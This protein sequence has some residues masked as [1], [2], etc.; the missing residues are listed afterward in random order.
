MPSMSYGGLDVQPS[1]ALTV[2][3][4]DRRKF[5]VAPPYSPELRP[6]SSYHFR[7]RSPKDSA[8]LI[9]SEG[10]GLPAA[11]VKAFTNTIIW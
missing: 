2:I 7:E 9:P 5:G 4:I 3:G 1:A 8:A 10:R 11:K 6:L